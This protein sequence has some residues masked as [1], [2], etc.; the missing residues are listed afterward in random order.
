MKKS[1]SKRLK[2]VFAAAA[3]SMMVTSMPA[4]AH[5][6][7][8]PFQGQ[9]FVN[10]NGDPGVIRIAGMRIDQRSCLSLDDFLADTSNH[11]RAPSYETL[12]ELY[13]S[14]AFSRNLMRDAADQ[15]VQ[16]CDMG[17]P[18]NIAGVHIPHLNKVGL[19]FKRNTSTHLNMVYMAH[20]FAHYTQFLNG[21]DYFDPNRTMYE[22]Q[23]VLLAMETAAPVAELIAMFLAEENGDRRASSAFPH[24]SEESR[25]YRAFKLEYRSQIRAGVTHD[26]ALNAAANKVWI[27][28]F[29]DQDK[30]DHYNNALLGFTLVNMHLL[31]PSVA[32]NYSDPDLAAAVR[33]AGQLSDTV[34]F[35]NLDTMPSGEAL[36]GRNDRMQRIFEAMEWY[37]QSKIYGADNEWVIWQQNNLRAN[38]NRYVDADFDEALRDI[39]KGKRADRAIA[40]SVSRQRNSF[41][42]SDI[43]TFHTPNISVT[44]KF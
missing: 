34:D 6:H 12:T 8:M 40:D 19:D 20:E 28:T 39:R 43:S 15:N 30:L 21:S 18:N 1:K 42:A 3:A 11:R 2:A 29:D 13:N 31:K 33:G 4:G 44:Y 23:R 24:R 25:W 26:D 36:F 7:S 16:V 27:N 17:L 35:T 22:N 32:A 38:G 14:S 9:Q 5:I 10:D 37:R 41:E